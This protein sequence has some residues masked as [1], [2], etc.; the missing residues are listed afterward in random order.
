M[1]YLVEFSKSFISNILIFSIVAF[2]IFFWFSITNTTIW[3][4]TS[5]IILIL[6]SYV[7]FESKVKDFNCKIEEEEKKYSKSIYEIKNKAQIEVTEATRLMIKA[8]KEEKLWKNTMLERN[9]GFK[10]LLSFISYFEKLRDEPIS[11]YLARKSHPALKASEVVKEET[12]KRREA[13]FQNKRT[14]ALIEMYE[15]YAP[16]LIE[17]KDDIPD[18]DDLAVFEAYSEEERQ[19]TVVNYLTKEEY[20]KLPTIERNQMALDRFWSRP[21]SKWLIGKIYERY[22]GYLYEQK[23]YIVE[24]FGIDK[25]YEDMGR[26]LVCRKGSETIIIQC[27]YWAEFRTIYEKHIFQLFGTVFE[28][29]EA[30]PNENVIAVFYT[31]TSLSPLARKISSTLGIELF[32]NFKLDKDY[33]CIKCNINTLTQEKIY[34]LPFDQRYDDTKIDRDGEKYCTTVAEAE[35]LGFRRAFRWHG[36]KNII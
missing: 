4:I 17:L 9:S 1:K 6:A 36:P 12:K 26:D 16:F 13:D 10:T 33:P 27:K 14:Q 31:S 8:E 21:K 7:V 11:T 20:R 23:G 32:E 25:K 5:F 15:Q 22:I 2:L 18:V 29:K 3:L 35:T 34:H 28:Y 24:Y 19:D 30:H